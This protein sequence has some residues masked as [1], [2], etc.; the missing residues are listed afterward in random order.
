MGYDDIDNYYDELEW[1]EVCDYDPSEPC[2]YDLY[3][4]EEDEYD[5]EIPF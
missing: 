5:D 2:Y 1:W 4:D 3:S